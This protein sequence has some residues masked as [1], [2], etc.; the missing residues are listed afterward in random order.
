MVY[1][2]GNNNS[3]YENFNF[4]FFKRFWVVMRSEV[5]VMFVIF[6]SNATIIRNIMHYFIILIPKVDSS[7][8]VGYF[9]PISI[10]GSLYKLAA[11]VL[12]AR[13]ALM[14]NKNVLYLMITMKRLMTYDL[15]NWG[16]LDNMIMRFGICSRWRSWICSCV[17]YGSLSILIKWLSNLRG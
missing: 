14:T 4:H 9:I 3:S 7:L 8:L 6:F 15:F 2:D 12:A 1:Y 17:F 10:F 5:D 13:L 16:L 11:K